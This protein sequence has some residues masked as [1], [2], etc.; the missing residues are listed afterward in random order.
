M[1]RFTKYGP[2]VPDALVQ[3]LEDDRVVI[4]CGAGVSMGAGLPSYVGLVAHCYREL[5]AALPEDKSDDWKWPD[6]MLGVL[7]NDFGASQVRRIV[8]KRLNQEPTDLTTHKAI[9]NLARLNGV[10]GLRLVTTNFDTFFERAQAETSVCDFH[11]GP[12]LPI[13]RDDRVVSWRSIA[14]LHGRL[15]DPVVNQQ[16]VMTSADFGRAYLTEGWAARFVARLFAD[17]TVLFIGYSLN[18]PVLRYMT[19]AFAAEAMTARRADLRE[20]AYIFVEYDARTDKSPKRWRDR[21]V[22]PI[23]YNKERQ[24]RRLR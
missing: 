1:P 9:L 11:S 19:D 5:G 22:E 20:R 4:F 10:E 17:F 16:L 18:D 21:G 12:V 23:F 15:G 7:E 24:H 3:A 6:R 2:N 14:Y 13:P 8:A